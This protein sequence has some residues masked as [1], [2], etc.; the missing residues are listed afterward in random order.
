LAAGGNDSVYT[1]HDYESCQE[2]ESPEPGISTRRRCEGRAGIAVIWNNEPDDSSVDFGTKPLRE[3]LRIGRFFAAGNTIEWR[4]P[5]GTPLAA[6]VRYHSGRRIGLL[7][8]PKLVVYRLEP[9]GR[10]CVMATVNGT[11][12]ANERARRLADRGAASFRC[13]VSRRLTR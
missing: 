2:I 5:A 11:Q 9:G 13:G 8:R 3:D 1:R 4:G 12:G 10:S 7:D 6:I